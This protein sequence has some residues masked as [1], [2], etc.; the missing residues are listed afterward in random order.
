MVHK[1]SWC[2]PPAPWWEITKC[3]LSVRL[4][5]AVTNKCK[6]ANLTLAG[7]SL[8]RGLSDQ[9]YFVGWLLS[10]FLITGVDSIEFLPSERDKCI[11]LISTWSYTASRYSGWFNYSRHRTFFS[12][13]FNWKTLRRLSIF[14]MWFYLF[15]PTPPTSQWIVPDFKFLTVSAMIKTKKSYEQYIYKSSFSG[16]AKSQGWWHNV[17][18]L[19][20]LLN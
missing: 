13:T 17:H 7:I 9:Y 3:W 5:K 18:L 1:S 10:E 6:R 11:N 20:E 15:H 19:S 2:Q 16:I 14:G 4:Q 12:R 8:G